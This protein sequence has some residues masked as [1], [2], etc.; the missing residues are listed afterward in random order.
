MYNAKGRCIESIP[1]EFSEKEREELK[2][3]ETEKPI[4]TM[5]KEISEAS[6]VAQIKKAACDFLEK[7]NIKTKKGD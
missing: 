7:N 3:F 6:T 4:I 5:V 1:F 2:K